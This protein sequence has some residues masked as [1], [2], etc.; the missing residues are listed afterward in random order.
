MKTLLAYSPHY[1]FRLPGLAA[2]HPFDASKYSRAWSVLREHFGE[3]LADITLQ[4][5][6]PAT[7]ESLA[8]AHSREYLASLS[9]SAAISRVVEN[10]LLKWLPSS[11]LQKG[12]LTPAKYAVAGTITAAHKAIEEEAIVF[13]LG[14]GFHH[15]FRDHGEGFCFFSDAALAIQLLRAEKRLGS[16]DEVLMIDLDA[17]RGNGFESYIAS[18]PMVHNF[19]MYNFQAY[20]GLHQGNPDEFPF[21]LPLHAGTDTEVY[22]NILREELP[23]LFNHVK[24]PKLAFYNAGTDILK[25]DK[26]GGLSVD[27][28]GVKA[29]DHFVLDMLIKHNIPTV[30]MTSGG[31]SKDSYRLIADLAQ[32]LLEMPQ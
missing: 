6:D 14:G 1:D 27:Y 23:R 32:H 30:I 19:D 7:T 28:N 22:L 10:S 24:Q 31:Y 29:R 8:L 9:H 21:M 26:L 20:P 11:L 5:N 17:H 12:L 18:D 16:A 4:I 2:L 13:N 15:A 3:K 25:G